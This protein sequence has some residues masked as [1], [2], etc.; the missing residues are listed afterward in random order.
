MNDQTYLLQFF[1]FVTHFDPH[2]SIIFFFVILVYL[3]LFPLQIYFGFFLD[4]MISWFRNGHTRTFT[5]FLHSLIFFFI[6]FFQLLFNF[7]FLL[8][9]FHLSLN[10]ITHFILFFNAL[11][12]INFEINFD[13]ISFLFFFKSIFYFVL[14]SPTDHISFGRN[15]TTFLFYIASWLSCSAV[16]VDLNTYTLHRKLRSKFFLQDDIMS[17][18]DCWKMSYINTT[19]TTDIIKINMEAKTENKVYE[20]EENRML[21]DE[22]KTIYSQINIKE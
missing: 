14:N 21:P 15:I 10:A 1:F 17:D 3:Y 7:F 11:P 4:F 12:Q 18:R 13:L 5:L 16:D 6:F 22:P 20:S 9:F 2:F 8:F 19:T